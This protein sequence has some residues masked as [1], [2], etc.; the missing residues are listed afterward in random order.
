MIDFT[1][2]QRNLIAHAA[3]ALTVSDALLRAAGGRDVG[4]GETLPEEGD[5][6]P[7]T[8]AQ[9]SVMNALLSLSWVLDETPS[10]GA[11]FDYLAAF[12]QGMA[13]RTAEVVDRE[14]LYDQA[15]E[16]EEGEP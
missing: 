12:F 2:T 3:M 15:D 5:D 6:N 13:D 1:E 8:E 7:L 14:Q 11:P 10:P 9:V 4:L 16:L